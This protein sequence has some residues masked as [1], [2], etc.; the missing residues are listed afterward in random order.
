M[1]SLVDTHEFGEH[2]LE[3]RR[4]VGVAAFAFTFSCVHP[5]ASAQQATTVPQR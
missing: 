4:S 1:Y 2:E 5:L 3:L